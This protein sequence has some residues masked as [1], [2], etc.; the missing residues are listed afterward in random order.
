LSGWLIYLRIKGAMDLDS[1][2]HALEDRMARALLRSVLGTH[3]LLCGLDCTMRAATVVLRHVDMLASLAARLAD[4]L[5]L[6]A[7]SSRFR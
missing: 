3:R 4:N 1:A 6:C 5:S 2:L 7:I